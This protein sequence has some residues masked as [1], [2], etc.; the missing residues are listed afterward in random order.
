MT[1]RK[2]SWTPEMEHGLTFALLHT[3]TPE[4]FI[5]A[6]RKQT[7]DTVHT[8]GGIFTHLLNVTLPANADV[9]LPETFM[10]DFRKLAQETNNARKLSKAMPDTPTPVHVPKLNIEPDVE[11]LSA[12]QAGSILGKTDK[13]VAANWQNLEIETTKL[14][15]QG[16]LV[17][18]YKRSSVEAKI[19]RAVE[20][21]T[22][23]VPEGLI[24]KAGLRQVLSARTFL[25]DTATL[26]ILEKFT[27]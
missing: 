4:T 14:K 15:V 22:V 1:Q 10:R 6:Y 24:S 19:P 21:K 25:G 26:N 2:N 5:A 7:Q 11:W 20:V 8:E 17:R 3:K 9:K 18:Y 27:E 13:W 23:L 12:T 16:E